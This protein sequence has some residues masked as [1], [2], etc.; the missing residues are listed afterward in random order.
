[1]RNTVIAPRLFDARTKT[2][3]SWVLILP[4]GGKAIPAGIA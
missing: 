3:I 2:S 4:S 1:M